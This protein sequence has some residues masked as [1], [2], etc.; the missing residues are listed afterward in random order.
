MVAENGRP[1]AE[2]AFW[3]TYPIPPAT[4]PTTPGSITVRM[5]PTDF[6]GK[7]VMHCHIL[8]HEDAGM[9]AVV[10]LV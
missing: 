9:M 10:N 2:P 6:T 4:G 1:V 3:D 7:I 5:A 8:P